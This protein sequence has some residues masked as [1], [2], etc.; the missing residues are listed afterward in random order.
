MCRIRDGESPLATIGLQ[1]NPHHPKPTEPP[2]F[3][4]QVSD[5]LEISVSVVVEGVSSKPVSRAQTAISLLNREKTG[6]FFELV[7]ESP[8]HIV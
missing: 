8:I 2:G 5:I 3:L 7:H 4:G 1:G 6:N